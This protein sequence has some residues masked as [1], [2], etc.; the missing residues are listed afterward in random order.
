MSRA[1]GMIPVTNGS[2]G[3]V[4]IVAIMNS[5]HANAGA[6]G[7]VHPATNA[8]ITNGADSVRRRLSVI[9]QRPSA[10]IEDRLS[11]GSDVAGSPLALEL[12]ARPRI[13]GS[14]CQS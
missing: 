3:A 1:R 10:G 8:S 12:C 9:F 6:G 2:I 11:R 13:H 14:S 4:A 5:V 7:N